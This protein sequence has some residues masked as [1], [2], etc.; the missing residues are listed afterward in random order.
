MRKEATNTER[1]NRVTVRTTV[2][3]EGDSARGIQPGA[4][5]AEDFWKGIGQGAWDY[6]QPPQSQGERSAGRCLKT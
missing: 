1:A 5:F 6:F 4:D 2:A 3:C